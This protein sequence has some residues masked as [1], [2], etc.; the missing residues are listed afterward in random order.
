MIVE[1]GNFEHEEITCFKDTFSNKCTYP[2]YLRSRGLYASRAFIYLMTSQKSQGD[3]DEDMKADDEDMKA[4]DEDMKVEIKEKEEKEKVVEVMAAPEGNA[5]YGVYRN[6][7]SIDVDANILNI[8]YQEQKESSF[9]AEIILTSSSSNRRQCYDLQS[10]SEPLIQVTALDDYDPLQ[11]GYRITDIAKG[12][13]CFLTRNLSLV[14]DLERFNNSF[15]FPKYPVNGTAKIIL[16]SPSEVWGYDPSDKTLLLCVVASC[17][18]EAYYKWY[19][20][21]EIVKEGFGLCCHPVKAAG[22]YKV[23]VRKN[24]EEEMSNS[25]KVDHFKP[26]PESKLEGND[27]HTSIQSK[28][29]VIDVMKDVQFNQNDILGSGAFGVVYRGT[30]RNSYCTK[31]H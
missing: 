17:H 9:S 2:E 12:N 27:V 16:H 14:D 20:D 19:L 22:V 24:E 31:T 30:W 7:D 8:S 6:D 15:L 1:L 23:S 4:D 18:Q 26:R 13:E 28:L 11:N 10:F 21:E 25:V 29:P 5:R 3:P